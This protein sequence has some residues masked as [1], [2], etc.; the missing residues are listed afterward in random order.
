MPKTNSEEDLEDEESQE[1]YSAKRSSA[2]L[3]E[4]S[5]GRIKG[6]KTQTLEDVQD[7]L[8]LNMTQRQRQVV[9]MIEQKNALFNHFDS[10]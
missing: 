2:E 3:D 1:R 5:V 7:L 6:M 9:T 4:L 8:P 10:P